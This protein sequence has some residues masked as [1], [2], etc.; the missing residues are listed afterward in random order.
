MSSY[1]LFLVLNDIVKV[2]MTN[3]VNTWTFPLS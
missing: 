3:D 2:T 1:I